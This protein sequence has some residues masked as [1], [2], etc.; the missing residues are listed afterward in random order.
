MSIEDAFE[1]IGELERRVQQLEH[2]FK[3]QQQAE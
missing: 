2:Y 3:K 1:W